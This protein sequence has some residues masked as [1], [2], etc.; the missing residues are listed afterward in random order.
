MVRRLAAVTVPERVARRARWVLD[1]LGRRDLALG[2]DLPYVPDAWESVERGERPDGDAVAEAFFHLARVE[3]IGGARD[4]RNRFPAGASCLDPLD[5]P[6]ERL[7]RE[8]GLEPPRYGERTVCRRAHARRR[9]SVALDARRDPRC[10][11]AAEARRAWPGGR[12][13]ARSASQVARHR[14]VLALPRGPRRR[15]GRTA[16]RGSTF[17]VMAAARAPRRRRVVRRPAATGR[18]GDP[19]VRRRGRAAR[20]LPRG[21]GHRQAR[22]RDEGGRAPRRFGRTAIATTTSASTRTGISSRSAR[23]ASGTTRRSASPTRSGSA[24]ASRSRSI[25]GTSRRRS[26]PRSSKCR[27]P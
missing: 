22:G 26:R 7:R 18:R 4:E 2:G 1:T 14:S 24:P 8:L 3:E 19:R 6:L 12:A 13:R 25:R 21:G 11:R 20:Q 17:Y 15:S 27:S 9:Q 5:P 10:G 16:R 23:S